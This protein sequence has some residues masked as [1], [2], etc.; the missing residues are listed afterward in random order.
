MHKMLY[1]PFAVFSQLQVDIV[2]SPIAASMV[3]KAGTSVTLTCAVEGAYP[4][5]TYQWSS[6]CTYCFT[7]DQTSSAVTTQAIHGGDSGVHS[8]AVNDYVGH[9]GSSN[10]SIQVV[11]K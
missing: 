9:T 6:D 7:Y 1:L 3:Y 2:A 5:L 10:I 11:G 4:P 8:C